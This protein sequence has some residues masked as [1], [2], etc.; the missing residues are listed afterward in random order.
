MHNLFNRKSRINIVYKIRVTNYL[1]LSKSVSI[2]ISI[3]KSFIFGSEIG[4]LQL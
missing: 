1:L 2:S 3:G 4:Q